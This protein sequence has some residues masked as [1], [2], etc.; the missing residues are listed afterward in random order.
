MDGDSFLFPADPSQSTLFSV[1]VTRSP[2]AEAEDRA[3]SQPDPAAETE[4]GPAELE[5]EDEPLD[6]EQG[7][8]DPSGVLTVGAFG[9]T[10]WHARTHLSRRHLRDFRLTL[11]VSR[12]RGCLLATV[13]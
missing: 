10:R 2:A 12:K 4:D 5:G 13:P 9:Y 11:S 1:G 6:I 7:A 3:L 8:R